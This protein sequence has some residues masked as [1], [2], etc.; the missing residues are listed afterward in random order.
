MVGTPENEISR[1]LNPLTVNRR[2]LRDQALRELSPEALEEIAKAAPVLEEI[3]EGRLQEQMREDVLFLTEEMQIGPPP[4]P[5]VTRDDAIIRGHDEAVR[6]F[7][8]TA[9]MMLAVKKSPKLIHK[10][11][12]SAGFK[13]LEIVAV[14]S[15]LIII[16]TALL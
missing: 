13:S 11:R 12:D 10:L 3:T 8:R 5:G 14:L 6:V 7:G 2:I 15:T 4:L 9:R 1:P 16:G